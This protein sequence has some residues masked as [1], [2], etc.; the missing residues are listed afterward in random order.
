MTAADSEESREGD[1]LK[2]GSESEDPSEDSLA[3]EAD[4]DQDEQQAG[5]HQLPAGAVNLD[6]QQ[7]ER[8]PAGLAAAVW[9]LHP[10]ADPPTSDAADF[11]SLGQAALTYLEAALF[12]YPS[13]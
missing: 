11:Y 3:N 13:M 2:D 5:R 4:L 12:M 9:G 1:A 10:S 7:T 6:E 8:T